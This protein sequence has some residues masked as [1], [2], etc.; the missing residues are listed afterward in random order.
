MRL[1]IKSN[2]NRLI[3]D[4]MKDF[5]TLI[6]NNNSNISDQYKTHELN[7]FNAATALKND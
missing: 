5:F 1:N 6:H 3:T 4:Q 7:L 2:I